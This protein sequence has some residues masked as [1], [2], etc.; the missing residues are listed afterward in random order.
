MK[1]N[2]NLF[3]TLIAA[4][5]F[6]LS[7]L[8]M[9]AGDNIIL[10]SPEEYQVMK[11]SPNGKW[12]CGVYVDYGYSCYAFRWNLESGT[13]ELL[14]NG[15]ESEAWCVSDDGVVCGT[16]TDRTYNANHAAI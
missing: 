6:A 10:K 3:L 2:K 16:Y 9:L 8:S 5:I 15:D 13:V 11:I 14:S 12:A 4:I 1:S 7:P